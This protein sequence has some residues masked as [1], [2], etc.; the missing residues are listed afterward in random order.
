MRE[1]GRSGAA[2]LVR[3]RARTT[4]LVAEVALA[5]VLLVGAGLFVTSFVRLTSVD[6]GMDVNNT[7]TVRV[8]PRVV[9]DAPDR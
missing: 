1:G 7:L 8:F 4:L 2:G 6:L 3:E 9:F 5:V